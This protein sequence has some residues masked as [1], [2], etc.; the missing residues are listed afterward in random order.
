MHEMDQDDDFDVADHGPS[1]SQQRRDALAVFDLAEKLVA[2]T[3]TQLKRVPM[4][5]SLRDAVQHTRR[6]TQHIARK[7][8]IQY[9]AKLMR[10]DD[11]AVA[12]IRR[13]LEGDRDES[14]RQ[15]AAMHRIEHQRGQLI[16]VGE[17]ELSA[18]FARYPQA[19]RQR[20]QHLIKAARDE[21]A[22]R[23][24]P[25]AFREIFQWIKQLEADRNA[26]AADAAHAAAAK[27][28]D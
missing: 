5:D 4:P 11:E 6:I 10:R 18:F 19:D 7:R 28:K 2:L 16:D 17:A 25:V 26:D 27:P 14:R 3:D 23:R 8:E 20:A 1:R 24:P 15:A 22:Q 12:A 9:L 13:A 21:R